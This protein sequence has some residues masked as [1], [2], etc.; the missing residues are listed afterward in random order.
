MDYDAVIVGAGLSGIGALYRLRKLGLRCLIVEKENDIG[1]VWCKNRYPGARIDTGIPSYVLDMPECWGSWTWSDTYP[2]WIE[3]Q[4]YIN[5]CDNKIS[6]RD[7]SMVKTRVTKAWFDEDKKKWFTL[8][9]NSTTLTSTYLICAVGV[10]S[11]RTQCLDEKLVEFEGEIHHPSEWPQNDV[12]PEGK[13]VAIIG[14]GCTGI[15][16][17]EAW[18]LRAKSLTVYQ[19]TYNTALPQLSKQ[20]TRKIPEDITENQLASREDTPSGVAHWAYNDRKSL[21]DSPEDRENFFRRLYEA[22]GLRFWLCGYED[23]VSDPAANRLAYD[24]WAR[25]TRSR[26]KDPQKRDILAPLT[27]KYLLGTRRPAQ[28]VKF[29]ELFDHETVNVFDISANPIEKFASDGIIFQDGTKKQ[30]D[31]II[32]AIGFTNAVDNIGALEIRG[33]DSK[34]LVTVLEEGSRTQLGIMVHGFPNMFIMCGP[35]A[36]SE[37]SNLPT[38][39]DLQLRWIVNVVSHAR[40]NGIDYFHP[41]RRATE[42]WNAE[43]QSSAT[44]GSCWPTSSRYINDEPIFYSG[45]IPRYKQFLLLDSLDPIHYHCIKAPRGWNVLK[46][47]LQQ[48]FKHALARFLS[49]H[50]DTADV[51]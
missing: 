2:E 32:P 28:E 21:D 14:T 22:G 12:S 49:S 8:C 46:L 19:R 13:D 17:A 4:N 6:I 29:Y 24:F 44:P 48:T 51:S 42:K 27:P 7:H 34:P 39:I 23:L 36:P 47:Y 26:I 31:I 15:Q 33:I 20:K 50:T 9:D 38:C 43:V 45:G 18:A 41:T 3:I 40:E 11:R 10:T 1:G 5:H 35:Q 30:H 37:Q 25:V 16:I